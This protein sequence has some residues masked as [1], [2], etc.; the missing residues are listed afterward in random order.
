MN[1][2]QLYGAFCVAIGGLL[3]LLVQ[4]RRFNRRGLGGLQHFRSFWIALLMTVLEWL[5]MAVSVFALLFGMFL[6][7]LGL[8]YG[9]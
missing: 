2:V 5:V 8:Y 6:L 1:N 3:W 7:L 4:H 9:N